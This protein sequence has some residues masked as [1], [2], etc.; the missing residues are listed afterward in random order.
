MSLVA[1]DG[2]ATAADLTTLHSFCPDFPTCSDGLSPGGALLLKSRDVF[3]TTYSGGNANS[4][5]VLY[6]LSR[7]G[8]LRLI[9]VFCK[10]APCRDGLLP[11]AGVIADVN[12]SLYGV[13]KEGGASGGGLIYKLAQ[14]ADTGK[15][16]Y[17]ILYSFCSA[18]NC[19]DGKTPAAGLTYQGAGT[20]AAYD[21]V[22]PLFGTAITGGANGQGVAYKLSFKGGS[23]QYAVIYNFCAQAGCSDGS[24]PAYKMAVDANGNVFGVA[25]GGT[26]KSGVAYELVPNGSTYTETVL[27]TFCQKKNCSDGGSPTGI[28]LDLGGNLIG[29]TYIG[30]TADRGTVFRIVPNGVSSQETVLYNFCSLANCADGSRPEAGFAIDASG[31]IFGTTSEGGEHVNGTHG[32][33]VFQVKDTT[34]TVLHS[35]CALEFCADGDEPVEDVVLDGAG[36]VYGSTA[37]GGSGSGLGGTIFRLKP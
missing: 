28:T 33:T 11:I 24:G 32:G 15:W 7:K 16:V 2:P 34:E 31:T 22:S 4:G 29:G 18:A 26:K 14:D 20:R 10:K 35:F 37:S 13:A 5:G 8:K 27:Y 23:P 17:T 9:H 6:E 21:G 1:V 25:G 30:G 19:G 3:G 36:N 12:G